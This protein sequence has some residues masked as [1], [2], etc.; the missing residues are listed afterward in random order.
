MTGRV[1]Q[2]VANANTFSHDD[3]VLYDESTGWKAS[4]FEGFSG[5]A[6][7]FFYEVGCGSIHGNGGG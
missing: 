4:L 3:T 6:L 7:G 1:V 2:F 5:F